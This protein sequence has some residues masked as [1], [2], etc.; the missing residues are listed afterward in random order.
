LLEGHGERRSVNGKWK[1][2]KRFTTKNAESTKKEKERLTTK[3]AKG[4]NKIRA[5]SRRWQR[6]QRGK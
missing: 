3:N 2:E 6:T 5:L 1:M 4:T